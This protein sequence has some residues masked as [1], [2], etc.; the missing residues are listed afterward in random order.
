MQKK[1][2]SSM[3][4]IS[5]RP[6][7]PVTLPNMHRSRLRLQLACGLSV[8]F[9]NPKQAADARSPTKAGEIHFDPITAIKGIPKSFRREGTSPMCFRA[10]HSA[11]RYDERVQI[12]VMAG[13]TNTYIR[14]C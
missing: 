5:I 11:V 6:S 2:G 8:L 12:K 14:F 1:A 10:N 4:V 9:P 3:C 7:H 13:D